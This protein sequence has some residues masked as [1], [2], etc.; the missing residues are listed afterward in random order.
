MNTNRPTKKSSRKT[1]QPARPHGETHANIAGEPVP[2]LPHERDE[3]ASSQQG[4]DHEVIQ[5]AAEDLRNGLEDT[6]RG[7]VL[8]E[9]HGRI[10]RRS[11]P[12][13]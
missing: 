13:D 3:S 9:L 7:P 6:D 1:A 10:F 8:E 12:P 11:A 2:R 4:P 5:Q